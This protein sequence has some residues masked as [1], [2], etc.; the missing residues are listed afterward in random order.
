M[1]GFTREVAIEYAV[2]GIRVNA[3]VPGYMLTPIQESLYRKYY[4]ANVDILEEEQMKR[5][6]TVPLGRHGEGWDTGYA[7]LFLASDEAKYITGETIVVDGGL[8][9]SVPRIWSMGGK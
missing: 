5:D 7:S 8:T 1:I 2:K 3:I 9:M 4:G 6:V